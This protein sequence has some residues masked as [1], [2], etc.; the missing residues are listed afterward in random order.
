MNVSSK[1]QTNDVVQPKD[2]FLPNAKIRLWVIV[3]ILNDGK[4]LLGRADKDYTWETLK[5]NLVKPTSPY[6]E[7]ASF[8]V[9]HLK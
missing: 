2:G 4:V 7:Y 5:E 8:E 6:D 1:F 9:A 3:E